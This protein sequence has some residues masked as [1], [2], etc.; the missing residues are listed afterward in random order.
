MGVR[1][2]GGSSIG[3]SVHV[4]FS[5]ISIMAFYAYYRCS[6]RAFRV[7]KKYINIKTESLLAHDNNKSHQADS[8]DDRVHIISTPQNITT[9]TMGQ[10]GAGATGDQEDMF[11]VKMSIAEAMQ[12]SGHVVGGKEI[13]FP[14]ALTCTQ[15]GLEGPHGA[16]LLFLSWIEYEPN[17]GTYIYAMG[18]A[19]EA[20][21][22]DDNG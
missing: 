15:E 16:P 9:T 22:V 12:N 8:D 7:T 4:F 19:T 1:N 13:I 2:D 18:L 21:G 11:G 17:V 3:N 14:S 5:N 10:L 20:A 6:S